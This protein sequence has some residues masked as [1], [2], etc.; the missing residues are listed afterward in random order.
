VIRN[1]SAVIFLACV[2]IGCS[3][4]ATDDNVKR[5]V[6]YAQ[7]PVAQAPILGFV[8]RVWKV[9]ESKQVEVGQMYV[10]ASTGALFITS[11]HGTPVTG[12]W[13]YENGVL[14]MVEDVPITA[15][16]VSLNQNG[17]RIQI[18]K[19][20]PVDMTLV[21]ADVPPFKP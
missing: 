12:S 4:P 6:P 1:L 16:I 8:N 20:S 15:K 18:S 3:S 21:A 5:P 13:K 10:F 9:S 19:P 7:P 11:P 14:T 17:L 2:V